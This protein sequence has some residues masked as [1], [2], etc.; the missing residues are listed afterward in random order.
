MMDDIYINGF[1][2]YFASRIM[3]FCFDIM[4]I[5]SLFIRVIVSLHKRYSSPFVPSQK[6]G[7]LIYDHLPTVPYEGG[8]K[9][10]DGDN[11]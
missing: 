4:L 1:M 8:R 2:N 11:R 9:G 3:L 7:Y 10:F 5:Y 6:F